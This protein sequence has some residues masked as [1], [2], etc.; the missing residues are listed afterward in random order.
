MLIQGQLTG[1][2]LYY[3]L[4]PLALIAGY[5]AVLLK[6]HVSFEEAYLAP[7][8][9]YLL[10]VSFFLRAYHRSLN[11]L[12]YLGLLLFMGVS[13]LNSFAG[14]DFL[15]HALVL[16]ITAVASIIVGAAIRHRGLFFLGIIFLLGDVS[17]Q[18]RSFLFGLQKWFWIGLG[19]SLFLALGLLFN[20]KRKNRTLN[21][22]NRQVER[23]KGWS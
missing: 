21:L 13:Y 10:V 3:F 16:G 4:A 11:Y 5:E 9:L 23:F 22:V 19:G 20:K 7:I 14:K 1:T 17:T 18:S 12:G 8:S 2:K 6:Y 15:I